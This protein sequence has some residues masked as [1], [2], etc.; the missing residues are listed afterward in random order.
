MPSSSVIGFSKS[1][2]REREAVVY[3]PPGY[4]TRAE[5]YPVLYLLHGAGGDE[6]PGR[7]RVGDRRHR[8]SGG[9]LPDGPCHP[10][11]DGDDESGPHA[12]HPDQAGQRTD[13]AVDAQPFREQ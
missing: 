3:L 1:L 11:G 5:R 12:P 4:S 7:Y 10:L 8:L 6:R 9:E 13:A 2:A